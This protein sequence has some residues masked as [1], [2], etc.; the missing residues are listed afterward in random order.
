M[1]TMQFQLEFD[2][3][4]VYAVLIRALIVAL[5]Q[6]G[7]ETDV[8]K[9]VLTFSIPG[10]ISSMYRSI[11]CRE[12]PSDQSGLLYFASDYFPVE[13][14]KNIRALLFEAG[15]DAELRFSGIGWCIVLMFDLTVPAML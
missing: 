12:T 8:S 2:P 3:Q 15:L 11:S 6:K 7:I 4:S 10:W 5:E 13:I 9:S 1:E 14:A